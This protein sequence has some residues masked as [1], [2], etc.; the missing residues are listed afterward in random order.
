M[1]AYA[2]RRVK[3]VK[4]EAFS[5]L[6]LFGENS[7][8]RVLHD[9]LVHY[10]VE[11]NHQGKDDLQLFPVATKIEKRVGGSACCNECLGGLLKYCNLEAA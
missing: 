10:H 6:I 9:F 7:L 11:R 4:E 8:W 3:S 2:E 1:N 5:K